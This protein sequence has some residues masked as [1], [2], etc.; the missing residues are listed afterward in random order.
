M[1]FFNY[2]SV[3]LPYLGPRAC[4]PDIRG[5]QGGAGSAPIHTR[6]M[7]CRDGIGNRP[8]HSMLFPVMDLPSFF[9]EECL[10]RVD[11]RLTKTIPMDVETATP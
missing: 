2:S 9:L 7:V 5:G 4:T 3:R 8:Q 11:A 10:C 6:L 1:G